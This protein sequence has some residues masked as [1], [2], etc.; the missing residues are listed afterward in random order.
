MALTVFGDARTAAVLVLR[1][2][3][4]GRGEGCA[5]GVTVGTLVPG[6][7]SLETPHLPY[8]LVAKDSDLPDLSMGNARATL[9]VTV[10]HKDADQAHDLAMLC[11]ALLLSHYGPVIRS[12]RPGTGPV[13]A[14]DTPS[15]IDLS[16][17]TVLANIRPQSLT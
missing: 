3:L 1:E 5:A 11:Q 2:A 10:W 9:R 13:P 17:L 7:R 16:S 8:V 6:D 4:A 12:V 15:G 14:V